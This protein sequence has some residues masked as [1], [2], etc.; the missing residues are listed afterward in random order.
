M[1]RE[2]VSKF[3]FVIVSLSCL[4]K[5]AFYLEKH[6]GDIYYVWVCLWFFYFEESSKRCKLDCMLSSQVRVSE[7]I[8]ALQLPEC[9]ETP[10]SKQ[11]PNLV[12]IL[13]LFKSCFI[14]TSQLFKCQLHKN[15]QTHSKNSS[16]ICR[17]IVW[18]CLNIL[19]GWRLRG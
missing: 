19:W 18:V 16:P 6:L 1:P 9:Q 11:S 3:E 17:W 12:R 14:A 15:D 4:L 10:C 13:M 2:W 7:W 8:Y 5:N